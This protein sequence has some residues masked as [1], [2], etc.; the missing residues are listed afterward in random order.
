MK[1]KLL[2]V[3]LFAFFVASLFAQSYA[4]TTTWPFLYEDFRAGTVFFSDA[5]TSKDQKLNIHL[6]NTTLWYEEGEELLR[7]DP[8]NITKIVIAADTFIYMNGEIV[9]LIQSKNNACLALLVKGNYNSLISPSTGA[10]GMDTQASSVQNQTSIA[11]INHVQIKLEKTE[12]HTL[13]LVKKYYF[14]FGDKIV[15]ASRKDIE[16]AVPPESLPKLRTF[17]KTH[18]IKWNEENS[19][20]RLFDFFVN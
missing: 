3:S 9:R 4:P 19:L 11:H 6:L 18:K 17:V 8:R 16:K 15:P 13:P 1:K 10:Y 12:G 2:I 5:G 7:S 14:I 20:K